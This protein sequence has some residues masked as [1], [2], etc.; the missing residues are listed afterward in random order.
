MAKQLLFYEHAVPLSAEQHRNWSLEP[1]KGYQFAGQT[2]SVPLAAV[3]FPD[4]AA[5]YVIVFLR[6]GEKVSPAVI[7]GRRADENLYLTS[8]GDWN[9]KYVPAFVQRYP[10]VFSETTSDNKLVLCIDD[11]YAGWNQEDRG[12]RLFDANAARTDYLGNILKFMEDFQRHS[13]RTE[14]FCE[15]LKALD[16]LEPMKVQFDLPSGDKASLSGFLAVDRKK[17]A[18]LDGDKLAELAKTS[19]LELIYVHLQSMRNFSAMLARGSG[20]PGAA[21]GAAPATAPGTN[22]EGL[23]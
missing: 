8:E 4:A 20:S 2:N 19:E 6:S 3:E 10:F 15:K 17:L 21:A 18:A 22:D 7:L 23:H 12:N 9:A 1:R 16:L 5:E 14:V 11:S 13:A